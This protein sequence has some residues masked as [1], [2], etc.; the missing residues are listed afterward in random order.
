MQSPRRGATWGCAPSTATLTMPRPGSKCLFSDE[1]L[2]GD[3]AERGYFL[4]SANSIN[5]GRILP[6]MVYYISA[7]CDLL[8]AGEDP[9]GGEGQRTA[10]PP[11]TSATSWPPTTP[12]QMG[13]P[14]GKL[15]CASNSNNVLTDFLR[16]GV[17]DR[18]RPFHNTMSP[19]MD[20]LISSNLERL[21]FALYRA[22]RRGRC[23]ATWSSWPRPGQ[24]EVSR[25]QSRSSLREHFCGGFCDD[26]AHPARPSAQVWKELRLPHRPP[27][28]RGLPCAGAVPEGDGGSTAH[29]RGLH[30]QPLQVL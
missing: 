29:H 7:Y 15:I 28:R 2:R 20:I 4:S 14:V 12:G 18:N 10:C 22:G 24:Y 9:D 25:G 13:L 3:L 26:A 1:T 8:R 23:G 21:L 6:Q 19:S 17:Y 11:G 16:T 30:R 27:H 5:W